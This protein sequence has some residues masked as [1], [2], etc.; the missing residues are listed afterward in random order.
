VAI[1]KYFYG[2][3]LGKNLVKLAVLVSRPDGSWRLFGSLTPYLNE[4]LEFVYSVRIA[5]DVT[6]NLASSTPFAPLPAVESPRAC[7]GREGKTVR[8]AS[9]CIECPTVETGYTLRTVGS[10]NDSE[11]CTKRVSR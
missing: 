9:H 11:R 5:S 1:Q 3:R 6:N 7:V 4:A 8:R 2:R 10:W